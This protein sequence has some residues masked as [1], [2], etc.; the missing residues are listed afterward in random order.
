MQGNLMNPD[1]TK[2]LGTGLGKVT[3][4]STLVPL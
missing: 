2:Y 3:K 1:V 4:T